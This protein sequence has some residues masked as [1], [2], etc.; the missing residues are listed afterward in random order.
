MSGQQPFETA[1]SPS[2]AE[3]A[4]QEPAGWSSATTPP[5]DSATAART[6]AR[7]TAATPARRRAPARRPAGAQN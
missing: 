7:V 5:T 2:P 1:A 3:S 4:G 6:A